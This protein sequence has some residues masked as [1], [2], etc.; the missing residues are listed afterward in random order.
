MLTGKRRFRLAEHVWVSAVMKWA[1]GRTTLED[2][3]IRK[4]FIAPLLLAAGVATAIAAAPTAMAATADPAP[5]FPHRHTTLAGALPGN[6]QL[7]D[8][9]GTP[10]YSPQ[11]PFDEGD[12]FGGYRAYGPGGFGSHGAFGGHGAG[13]R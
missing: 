10:Q 2:M 6:V 11:Y 8:S 5:V 13:H 12:Y 4:N 7:N 3:Q 1:R 9:L